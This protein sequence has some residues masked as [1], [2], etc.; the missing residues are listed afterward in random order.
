MLA[1]GLNIAAF[2]VGIAIGSIIGGRVVEDMELVDTPWIG[3]LIVVFAII[4]T[5][6]SGFLDSRDQAKTA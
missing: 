2:H 6:V 4:L 1:S 3:A 5:N